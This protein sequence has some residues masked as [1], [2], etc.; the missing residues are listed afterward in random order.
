VDVIAVIGVPWNAHELVPAA[1]DAD[2]LGMR[3]C[4]VDSEQALAKVSGGVRCDRL[5]VTAMDAEQIARSLD[6]I[7][8]SAVV[9]ITEFRL[10]LAAQVREKLGRP[11][12]S[13]Q[14][15]RAVSDKLLTRQTLADAGL[16]RVQF[17]NTPI[18]GLR[19]MVD[20]LDFPLVVKPRAFAGSNG[21]RL[22]NG[23]GDV[24]DA[25]TAFDA[26]V[27]AASSRDSL[28]IESFIPGVEV[29]AEG[30]VVDGK[31]TLWS[32]TDKVNT[33]PPYFQE[34]GH[35][36][37]SRECAARHAEVE[38]YLRRVVT[39]LGIGTAPI[40]AELMLNNDGVELVEIHTRFGGGHIVRLLT[41]SLEC[42]PFR[43]YFNALLSGGTPRVGVPE[44]VWGVGHF[45][46]HV[47][48]PFRWSSFAFPH[49]HALREIDLDASRAPK[50]REV[51]GIRIRY[52]RAG[53]VL[54]MSP[55]YHEVYAN[56]RFMALQF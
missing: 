29:S 13:S 46:A 7:A 14:A 20:S 18:A 56:V 48:H 5:A 25:V 31:L 42:R 26:D 54:F 24:A 55:E 19:D 28:L 44:A 38:E 8:P 52:W 51:E 41:E 1:E 36:M 30:L 17:W 33:G 50:V 45:T 16:T 35:V 6:G 23:P 22:L 3:L 2:A 27:A 32:L 37:P 47:G 49:P 34:I 4:L 53:H 39:A 40:H 10:D 9:S 21:V 15:E 12:T 43:A 11:G